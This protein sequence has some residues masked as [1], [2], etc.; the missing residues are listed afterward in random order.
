[1]QPL[2]LEQLELKG[3]GFQRAEEP[4]DFVLHHFIIGIM[5]FRENHEW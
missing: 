4:T 1:M 3:L 2:L 5:T